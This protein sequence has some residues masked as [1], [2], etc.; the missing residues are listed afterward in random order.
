MHSQILY[1]IEHFVCGYHAHYRHV[2][3]VVAHDYVYAH[4][5]HCIAIAF[6]I[7]P[8]LDNGVT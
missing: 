4:G 3:V 6:W 2:F 5:V 1:V 8:W 7:D